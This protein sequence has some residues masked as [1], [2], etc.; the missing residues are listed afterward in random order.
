MSGIRVEAIYIAPVKSLG[1]QRVER[2]QLGPDG[3]AGDRRFLLVDER[4]KLFTQREHGALTQVKATYT[5]ER[6]HLSVEFPGGEV[7]EGAVRAGAPVTVN[8]FGQEDVAAL[9]LDGPWD[10][11]F[12]RFVGAPLRLVRAAS[13][14]FDM[15]PVSMLSAASVAELQ[16][17]MPET[18]IDERRFRP[19]FYITGTEAHG[20]DAWVGRRVRIGGAVVLV[21]MR[22]ERCV[23][24]THNPDSG[25][26]DANTLKVIAS[27]RLD[28]PKEVNFGVYGTVAEPGAV[29]VGDKVAP[30]D[31]AVPA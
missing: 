13:T 10:A 15:L 11:A 1:L 14:A 23:M 19:N 2:V 8:F 22:D 27:Y 5:G 26:T 9:S 29:A 6:E 24:T 18:R 25:E 21:R 31:E 12:S 17:H 28:Q 30:V 4:G 16:R 7:A 3:I 20:E